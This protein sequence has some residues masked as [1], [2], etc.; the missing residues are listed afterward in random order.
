MFLHSVGVIS[1]LE[2]ENSCH[3]HRQIYYFRPHQTKHADVLGTNFWS[4]YSVTPVL[5]LFNQDSFI[6]VS[7]ELS[8]CVC[9]QLCLTL[10]DPIDC[11]LPCS[12]VNGVFS[13]K[14]TEVCCHFLLQGIFPTQGLNLGLLC[15]LRL[16]VNSLLRLHL[17]SFT[18]MPPAVIELSTD[19]KRETDSKIVLSSM[20]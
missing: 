16:Q 20:I 8:A 11:S 19:I 12:S 2:K 7:I 9:A 6:F 3:T 10:C 4:F 1:L 17:V 18:P 15:P 5:R 14:N 13:S